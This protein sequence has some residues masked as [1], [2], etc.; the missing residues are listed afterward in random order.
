MK[1]ILWI[2]D[3]ANVTG[4]VK[5]ILE[6]EGYRVSTLRDASNFKT[7]LKESHADLVLLDLNIGEFNGTVICEYIK[8]RSDLNN[9]LIILIAASNDIKQIEK[10]CGAECL[11]I[12]P[13]DLY[14]LIGT[15]KAYA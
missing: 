10:E 9:L 7:Q 3:E 1:K 8:S 14:T 2:E 11:I 12:K 5:V 6:H 15:V 4:L 13:F